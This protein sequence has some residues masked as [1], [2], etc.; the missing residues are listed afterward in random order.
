MQ[1]VTE[2]AKKETEEEEKE[3]TEEEE[4]AGKLE[5]EDC[6]I[7]RSSCSDGMEVEKRTK[8]NKKTEGKG[9]KGEI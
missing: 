1:S 7:Y 6:R 4:K 2:E 9:E 3:E 8:E 5:R